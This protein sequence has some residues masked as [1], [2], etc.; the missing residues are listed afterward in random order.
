[1]SFAPAILLPALAFLCF[2]ISEELV[3]RGYQIRNA[4]EGLKYPVLGSRGAVL[5]AWILSS[6]FFGWQ[7]GDNPNATF[8]ATLNIALAGLMFGLAYVLTGELAIPIGAHVSWNFFEGSVYGFPVSGLEPSG[9]AFL[10]IEQRGRDLWTGGLFGPEAGLLVPVALVL[11]GL[12]ITLWVRLRSGKVAIHT[13]LA[14]GPKA[15]QPA[16][17][18]PR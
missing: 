11:G 17:D 3:F 2:G 8:L 12:L 16:D 13:P 14:E 18:P 9:A 5:M 4:A 7:H 6:A 10:S 1:M 15:G